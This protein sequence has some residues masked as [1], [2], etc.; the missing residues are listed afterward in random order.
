MV[1]VLTVQSYTAAVGYSEGDRELLASS[2][3]TSAPRSSAC[4]RWRRRGSGRSSSRPSTAWCRRW[5]RSSTSTRCSGW[6]ASGCASTFQAGHRLRRA[7][8]PAHGTASS[9]PITSERGEPVLQ[10]SIA[11]GTGAHR[12]DI[13]AG[14]P[15][16]LNS[17]AEIEGRPPATALGTPCSSYLGVPIMLG[18]E[19]IGVISVPGTEVE[20]R[21][22]ARG[23]PA[24]A[25]RSRRTSASR[26]TTPGSTARPAGA[27]SEM[28]ALAESGA[29]G[30]RHVRRRGGARA[31]GGAGPGAARG[32]DECRPAA[33]S[34][35]ADVPRPRSWSATTP[36]RSGATC[37][38]W[39]RASSAT[40]RAVR[41]RSSSTTSRSIAARGRSRAPRRRRASGSWRP[42]CSRAS[43]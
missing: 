19:A 16:L 43:R 7:A 36:R 23:R 18:D 33:G 34:G 24:A 29:R 11:L 21:F 12:R 37:S 38:W 20:G 5:P 25:P 3:S 31:H 42:R 9:S 10:P 32:S 30:A 17:V 40:S 41:R 15:L 13:Q 26:S 28:A 22:R 39:A 2:P 8:R 1:G 6:S 35:R 14:R 4:A 27:R